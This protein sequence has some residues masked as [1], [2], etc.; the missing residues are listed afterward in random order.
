MDVQITFTGDQLVEL[1]EIAD[2]RVR[3]LAERHPE[4][5]AYERAMAFPDSFVEKIAAAENADEV[6][7]VLL[8]AHGGEIVEYMPLIGLQDNADMGD[9]FE[10]LPGEITIQPSEG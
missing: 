9:A 2:R 3:E 5:D 7:K 10:R 4:P 6:F 1:S 8:V